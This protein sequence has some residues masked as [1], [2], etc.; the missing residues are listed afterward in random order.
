[1]TSIVCPI[2]LESAADISEAGGQVFEVKNADGVAVQ[3]YDATA[4]AMWLHKKPFYPHAAKPTVIE[5]ARLKAMVPDFV[6]FGNKASRFKRLTWF[7]LVPMA[8]ANSVRCINIPGL[9]GRFHAYLASI[10][11]VDCF[12][13]VVVDLH[14]GD[15]IALDTD[16]GFFRGSLLHKI[17]KVYLIRVSIDRRNVVHVLFKVETSRGLHSIE[18]QVMLFDNGEYSDQLMYERSFAWSIV[19]EGEKV[20]YCNVQ[21]E[22]VHDRTVEPCRG[23]RELFPTIR[24]P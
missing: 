3:A 10:L 13:S 16:R 14:G 4:L 20:I 7:D 8:S 2:T 12:G 1:M 5:L 24:L 15:L 22:L 19:V 17:K 21:G 18:G 9:T 23:F 6:P 11:S